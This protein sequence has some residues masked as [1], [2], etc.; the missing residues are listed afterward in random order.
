MAENRLYDTLLSLPLFLGLSRNDLHHAAGITKFDF[1]KIKEGELI[2]G[3]G[4]C[5]QHL[6]FLLTGDVNVITD[7]DD[8]GYRIEE[9]I[10]APEIFQPERIFG[11]S[12]RFTHTYIAR[13]NCSVMRLEKQ[14]V[15]KLSQEFAIFRINLLNLIS[16]QTQKMNRRLLSVPPKSLD[17]RIIR[18]FETHCTRPAGE[19]IFYIKMNRIAEELNDSRLDISR[20][21]NRL[22]AGELLS[23]NRGRIHIPALEKLIN[24]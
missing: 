19:K 16:A 11:L 3:E 23:L 2:V 20:A 1:Q 9:D 15:L 13:N 17:E 8:H 22:K 6:F 7:A 10:T 18:F 21:L 24:R 4:E 14:D 5:C 12:Q